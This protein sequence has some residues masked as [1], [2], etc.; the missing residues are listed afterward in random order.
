MNVYRPSNMSQ[1]D[2]LWTHYGD[3]TVSNTVST[4]P[5][6]EVILTEKALLDYIQ[7][8]VEGISNLIY[9]EDPDDN[10]QMRLLG[11]SSNGSTLTIVKIPKEIH[12]TGFVGR[13]ATQE[14]VDN[15]FQYEVGSK[16]LAI[17]LNDGNEFLVSL[18]ELNLTIQGSESNTILTTVT[19]SGTINSNLKISK[20]DN[21]LSVIKLKSNTSGLYADL[22]ISTE[23]SGV[24]ITKE[25]DGIKASIPLG[26]TG[27]NVKF[28]ILTLAEYMNLSEVDSG[29][30]YFISDKQYLY[31]GDIRY[32]FGDLSADNPISKVG[33]DSDNAVLTFTTSEGT[34]FDISLGFVSETTNGMLTSE[35]YSSL[36]SVQSLSWETI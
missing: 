36:S 15:G 26:T 23:D 9:E 21:E 6:E 20:G 14:D 4:S 34:T 31:L 30:I 17:T 27:N 35:Q 19:D 5:S 22:A 33:Y 16:V 28:K 3:K 12:I 29:T 32:G 11:Q 25:S 2:Y 13:T 7:N 8:N 10:S 1:L 24:N 18:E